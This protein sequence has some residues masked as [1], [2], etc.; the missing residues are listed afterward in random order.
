MHFFTRT[1]VTREASSGQFWPYLRGT[2]EAIPR[3]R[4]SPQSPNL[5]SCTRPTGV[6]RL[7]CHQTSAN[8]APLKAY[9]GFDRSIPPYISLS[10]YLGMKRKARERT[11]FVIA[12]VVQLLQR[13]HRKQSAELG[14][15]AFEMFQ[16]LLSIRDGVDLIEVSYKGIGLSQDGLSNNLSALPRVPW[17]HSEGPVQRKAASLR[18]GLPG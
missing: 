3:G 17:R 13:R 15:V 4:R 11:Y 14:P 1:F 2:L 9:R 10:S 16:N 6:G 8:T 12:R 5:S 18:D 7:R